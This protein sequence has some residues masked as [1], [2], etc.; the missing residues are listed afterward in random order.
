MLDLKLHRFFHKH[1]D[2]FVTEY[3][4]SSPSEGLAE[5]FMDFIFVPK[6][7]S[8]ML[9]DQKI[10]FFYNYPEMVELRERLLINL[11]TYVDDQ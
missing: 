7:S 4:A 10:R 1:A 9:S 11:C 6:P 8:A 5:S 2:Q 3:A